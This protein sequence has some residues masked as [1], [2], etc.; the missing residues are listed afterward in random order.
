MMLMNYQAV[1]KTALCFYIKLNAGVLKKDQP[2]T[3]CALGARRAHGTRQSAYT[4]PGRCRARHVHVVSRP[5]IGE[6]NTV[7]VEQGSAIAPHPHQSGA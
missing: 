5:Y 3:H 6:Y 7:E 2:Y 4:Y 1:F